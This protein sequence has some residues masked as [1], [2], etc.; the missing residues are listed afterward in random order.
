MVVG[1]QYP[2]SISMQNSGSESWSS[3]QGFRLGS[4]NPTDNS[5]WGTHRAEVVGVVGAGATAVFNF[6]ARAPTNPG[7]YDFQWS[8]VRDGFGW[9]GP[10]PNQS[11]TVHA[12]TIMGNIEGVANGN[13]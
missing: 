12:S 5:R 6:T 11:V 3:A 13:I 9:F 1:Q 4:Q 7:T 10:W 2:V 8:M